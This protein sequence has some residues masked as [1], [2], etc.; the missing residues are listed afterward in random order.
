MYVLGQAHHDLL[1]PKEWTLTGVV[2]D[3]NDKPISGVSMDHS[4]MRQSIVTD[5]A[6]KFSLRT[7]APSL[8]MRK[9]GYRSRFLRK[10]RTGGEVRV[11]LSPETPMALKPCSATAK[12]ETITGYQ[13]LFCF[14]MISAVD[15]SPQSQNNGFGA[16]AYAVETRKG[17]VEI[18]HGSGGG[19]SF[20]IPL[21]EDV[22]KS[23]EYSE[24]AYTWGR[25][26]ILDARGTTLKKKHWRYIGR[27]GES[28]SYTDAD[29]EPASLLDR[30]LDGMCG[31]P[32]TP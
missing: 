12:C 29:E 4:G 30:F 16:R 20:G 7:R 15:P 22:W 21:D 9:P 28:A 18:S 2:V 24:T 19:Y 32:G 8:V 13:A 26:L 10:G 23:V 27:L 6:G 25:L 17:R 1:L 31:R 11:T 5:A 3:A 14:P